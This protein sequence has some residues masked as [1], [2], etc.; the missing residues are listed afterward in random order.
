MNRQSMLIGSVL[1]LAVALLLNAAAI[2]TG[3]RAG[4]PVLPAAQAIGPTEQPGMYIL[5]RDTYFLTSSSD[6]RN[7]YLWYYD[8]S[9][10]MSDNTVTLVTTARAN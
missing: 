5:G 6:G 8:F 1:L 2:M 7:V 4:S 9:P 10:R 3:N